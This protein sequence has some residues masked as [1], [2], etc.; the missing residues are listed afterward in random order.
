MRNRG[1]L[2]EVVQAGFEPGRIAVAPVVKRLLLRTS[3]ERMTLAVFLKVN[4][5]KRK[6]P[7]GGT[8]GAFETGR[9]RCLG[10]TRENLRQCRRCRKR[11]RWPVSE[12]QPESEE[13][14]PV[15]RGE[16]T[17]KSCG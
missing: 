7:K 12:I 14:R 10:R 6:T 11:H 4:S 2:S 8:K 15:A 1:E 16:R 17:A 3:T 13:A 9:T 5:A